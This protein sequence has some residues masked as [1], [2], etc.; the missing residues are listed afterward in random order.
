MALKILPAEMAQDPDRLARFQREARS[1]AAL[2]HPNIV[3]LF[4]VEGARLR[5]TR[6]GRITRT[7][8]RSRHKVIF[9]LCQEGDISILP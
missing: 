6:T 3:T 5:F 9:L 4:P 1:V 7:P 2:N 8:R